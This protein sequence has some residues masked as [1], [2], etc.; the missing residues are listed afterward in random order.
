MWGCELKYLLIGSGGSRWVVSLLVRLWVEINNKINQELQMYRQP[1]CEAVSW[2]MKSWCSLE[3][4]SQS[5]SL[6]GCELKCLS[7]RSGTASS[8][9][10]PCE[11]VSWNELICNSIVWSSSASLW[12]CELK[13]CTWCAAGSLHRQPPCEAVSWNTFVFIRR[14]HGVVSLLVR[15]WVEILMSRWKMP[16]IPSASLWGCELKWDLRVMVLTL[17]RQP[18]CEAV[19]WNSSRTGGLASAR[20]SASLWGCELKYLFYVNRFSRIPVSLLVRLWVEM[21]KKGD[22]SYQISSSA[23]LWGCELKCKGLY[24]RINGIRSAS[25]WG[26][27]LKYFY[28]S[29]YKIKDRQPPCEAV[30]WNRYETRVEWVAWKSASLWGCELKSQCLLRIIRRLTSASLWGCELKYL[31]YYCMFTR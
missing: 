18:P 10:P 11:A 3:S 14:T 24:Q 26:C 29:M 23:S 30:S 7:S 8:R 9:Q 13:W 5:A 31:V 15:L 4:R 21:K 27:E 28:C 17:L 16:L 25:L 12:G 2:N 1:P 22:R 6:W 20:Q 19:S